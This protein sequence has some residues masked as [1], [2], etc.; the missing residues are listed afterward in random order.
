MAAYF[1]DHFVAAY[2]Q[3]GSFEVIDE[4]GKLQRNGGNVAS[5]FCLPDGRVIDALTGP[6]AADELL[7]E[8]RWA[9]AASDGAKEGLPSDMPARLAQAHAQAS[10][11]PGRPGHTSKSRAIHDLLAKN[12]LPALSAVYQQVFER[13]LGQRVNLPGDGLEQ[14]AEA[15]ATAKR[16][17]LP[18]LFVLHK[19]ATNAA[20]IAKWN[21]ILAQQRKSD[22]DPLPKLAESYLVVALPLEALPAASQRLGIR[23]Y[24]APDK[25]SPLFVVARPDARQ[26]TAVST[27]NRTDELTRALALGMV[28][29]AKEQP[30]TSDQLSRLLALV[31][32]IDAGLAGNVRR[33]LGESKSK[34]S[35]SLPRRRG[36]KVASSSMLMPGRNEL[37]A[38]ARSR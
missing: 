29:G 22:P 3:V 20:A 35:P 11:A 15:V 36:E 38:Q 27:W 21:G 17:Q 23:P 9:V 34:A 4:H 16:R 24:A 32:P 5:Y 31:Q 28:Q 6:V 37:L 12:P 19:E 13:I 2:Q 7:E 25:E 1:G 18:I 10:S 8:A 30:R 33:L 26:L 14:V